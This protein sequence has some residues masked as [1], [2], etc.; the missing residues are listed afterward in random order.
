VQP[1][2]GVFGLWSHLMLHEVMYHEFMLWIL[3][4][5]NHSSCIY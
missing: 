1:I 2:N 3:M 5:S 4:E